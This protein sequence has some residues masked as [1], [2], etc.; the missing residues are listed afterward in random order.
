MKTYPY[1]VTIHLWE[2][3]FTYQDDF[4]INLLVSVIFKIPGEC[5]LIDES[6]IY[7]IHENAFQ[8]VLRPLDKNWEQCV[9]LTASQQI[10]EKQISPYQGKF[11]RVKFSSPSQNFDIFLWRKFIPWNEKGNIWKK[12]TSITK[13]RKFSKIFVI[14]KIP[15]G[16][17]SDNWGI[18]CVNTI[19]S[20]LPCH[21]ANIMLLW[22]CYKYVSKKAFKL[23]MQKNNQ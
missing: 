22:N 2:L 10:S 9:F 20:L 7:D 6:Q 14:Y 16:V 12:I 17:A 5:N 23:A 4:K 8:S 15:N 3:I 11:R 13:P 1:L 18:Y 21:Y 19:L